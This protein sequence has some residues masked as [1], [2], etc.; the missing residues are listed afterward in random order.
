M[1]TRNLVLTEQQAQWVENLVRSGRYQNASEVLRDGLRLLQRREAEEAAK[2]ETI[3]RALDEG[4]AAVADGDIY[5]FGPALFDDI[6]KEQTP[7]PG[8]RD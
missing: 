2:L 8:L 1:P 5:D 4:E 3:R 6:E 7:V